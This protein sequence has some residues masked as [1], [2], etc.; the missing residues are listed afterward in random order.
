MPESDQQTDQQPLP[1]AKSVEPQLAVTDI[2]ATVAHWQDVIGF[3][4]RWMWGDPPVHAG[5]NWGETQIQFTLNPKLAAHA[6]GQQIAINVTH[7]EA[8]YARHQSNG[9]EIVEPLETHPWGLAEYT[10]REINGYRLRI[11]EPAANRQKSS[12]SMPANIRIVPRI[13]TP[14]EYT[15]LRQS[16]GWHGIDDPEMVDRSLAAA[17]FGV[18]AEDAATGQVVGG[19]LLLGDNASFYY[20]KD[21]NVHPDW[22]AKRVGSAIMRALVEWVQENAPDSSFVTLFTGPQLKGFYAQFGFRPSYGMG[23]TIHKR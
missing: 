8:L 13:P 16:V 17:V 19:A 2:V 4:G 3:P 6:E 18:V 15:S 7:I 5:V 22:Q 23:M 9:A 14:D 11:G 20:V 1:V 12:P 21:V 10:V